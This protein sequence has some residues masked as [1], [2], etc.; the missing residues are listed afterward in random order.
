MA[1]LQEKRGNLLELDSL[2]QHGLSRRG[3]ARRV[4]P[5]D[6]QDVRIRRD[7]HHELVLEAQPEKTSGAELGHDFRN[8]AASRLRRSALPQS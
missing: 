4:D 3:D 2:L 7:F 6:A 8:G 1:R 5:N